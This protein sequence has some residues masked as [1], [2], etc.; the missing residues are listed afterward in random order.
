MS[1][2]PTILVKKADGT[3]ARMPLSQLKKIKAAPQ[4]TTVTDAPKIVAPSR[5]APVQSV[6]AASPSKLFI[7]DEYSHPFEDLVPYHTGLPSVST[8]N[9]SFVHP[10]LKKQ[11]DTILQ[12]A[13]GKPVE[14]S[15][16]KETSITPTMPSQNIFVQARND[17]GRQS[18]HDIQPIQPEEIGPV[19]EIRTMTLTDWRRLSQ[20]P[21][22]A[23]ARLGQKF[24]NI[25]DES[26]LLYLSALVAWRQSPLFRDYMMAVAEGLNNRARID[27]VVMDKSRIQV[28]EIQALL[29]MEKSFVI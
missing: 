20:N 23:A 14:I 12:A 2:E 18:M 10:V 4:A 24:V 9:N 22:E 7:P 16:A 5:S 19:D 21:I 29:G 3:I 28:P 25:N 6:R 11:R 1:T 13:F 15:A 26:V 8:P 17:T 27:V